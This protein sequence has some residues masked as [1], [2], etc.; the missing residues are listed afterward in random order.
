MFHE[1]KDFFCLR[2]YSFFISNV[3]KQES[4][5][6][7]EQ[8]RVVSPYDISQSKSN[9]KTFFRFKKKS[10]IIVL[11]KNTHLLNDR[12]T[13]YDHDANYRFRTTSRYRYQQNLGFGIGFGR[14]FGFGRS[15]IVTH[16]FPGQVK[17][18]AKKTT[19]KIQRK[20]L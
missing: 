2:I 11:I 12:L 10:I 18:F 15:L 1:I 9:L 17:N 16:F 13:V 3:G 7:Q 14:L 5:F 8:F 4:S 20:C 6:T 19:S